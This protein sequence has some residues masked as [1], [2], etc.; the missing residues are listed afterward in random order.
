[1]DETSPFKNDIIVAG[2]ICLDIILMFGD[3]ITDL[4]SAVVPGKCVVAENGA[5]ST[6]G[7]VANTGLALHQLGIPTRLVAKIGADAFGKSMLQLLEQ[8]GIDND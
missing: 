1:M 7:S 3:N 8:K 6:G 2:Q 5:I 4:A